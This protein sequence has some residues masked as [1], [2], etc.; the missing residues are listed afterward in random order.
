ME[1]TKHSNLDER[2]GKR[3]KHKRMLHKKIKHNSLVGVGDAVRRMVTG[4]ARSSAAQ[5]CLVD[6]FSLTMLVDIK[7]KRFSSSLHSRYTHREKQVGHYRSKLIAFHI[8]LPCSVRC[9]MPRWM[10]LFIRWGIFWGWANAQFTSSAN[11][12][13]YNLHIFCPYKLCRIASFFISAFSHASIINW[14]FASSTCECTLFETMT[15]TL[16]HRDTKTD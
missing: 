10:C 11:T 9:K 14:A 4:S 12:H 1:G 13:T 3:P 7:G 15:H 6:P 16:T 2:R 5:F 8:L